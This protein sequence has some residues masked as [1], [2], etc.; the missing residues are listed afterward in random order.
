ML[1]PV[2]SDCHPR[3][4]A[5]IRSYRRQLSQEWKNCQKLREVA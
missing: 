5:R 4:Y 1:V 2:T 3:R